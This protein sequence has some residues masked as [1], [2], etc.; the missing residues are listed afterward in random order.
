MIEYQI[1]NSFLNKEIYNNY[2]R[3]YNL[4]YVKKHY[5]IVYK[6][7]QTLKLLWNTTSA[8]SVSLQDVEAMF[9]ASYPV[10]K[11][12]ERTEIGNT[13]RDIALTGCSEI[14]KSLL[15][16]HRNRSIAAD[17]SIMALDV[18]EGREDALKLVEMVSAIG[19]QNHIEEEQLDE[20]STDIEE[21]LKTEEDVPGLNWRLDCLNVSLGPIRKG[22]FGHIF[23]RIETGKSAMW[24]SEAT[25]MASQLKN[26]E[27]IA[28][29]FNEEN[30]NDVIIRLYSAILNKTYGEILANPKKAKEDFYRKGGDRLRFFDRPQ[31]TKKEIEYILTKINP[32]LIIIDNMDKLQGF[33]ADR[34]D[35]V[36]WE[37]YKWGRKLAKEY[38]PVLS[39]G[40]AD[41]TADG[42]KWINENQMDGGKTG[43]PSETDFTIGIGKIRDDGYEFIRYLHIS[44]NKL[45][46]GKHSKVEYRHGKF[47][48]LLRPEYSLYEDMRSY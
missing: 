33:T 7:Q 31:L 20:S 43:K 39:V 22:N 28:I 1:I 15:E 36:L 19:V 4:D 9:F 30:K 45:K 10:L 18:A 8:D 48:V 44:R 42:R 11:E 6:I 12:A 37:I 27:V 46:G 32:G 23:A 5:P 17:C 41:A 34:N 21:I 47:D 25:Y 35:L 14:V 13:F 40:Q 24:I 3:F 38:C 29:F 2:H 16:Q 26:D